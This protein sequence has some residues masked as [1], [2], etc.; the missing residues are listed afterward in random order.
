[1]KIVKNVLIGLLA[2]QFIVIGTMKVIMPLFGV[3]MFVKNMAVLN[4]SYA[5]TVFIGSLDLLGGI[6]LL[7][8]KWRGYAALGLVFLMQGA[9]GS[10]ITHND[11]FG[12]IAGGAGLACVLLVVL[13]FLEKPF[14]IYDKARNQTFFGKN[15]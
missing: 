5:W 14:S 8:K 12:A 13:L 3:D 9:I 6:G 1:M 7:F 11:A 2:F 4:Y 10:H 15:D